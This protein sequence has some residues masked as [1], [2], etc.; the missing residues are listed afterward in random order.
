M[1]LSCVG[2]DP[3]ATLHLEAASSC[4]LW[5]A[6]SKRVGSRAPNSPNAV[7]TAS[8]NRS[9]DASSFEAPNDAA[10]RSSADATSAT[11][12]GTST[13][14]SSCI[15]FVR[16]SCLE[17]SVVESASAAAT[18]TAGA[19]ASSNG[20]SRINSLRS[21]LCSVST[22]SIVSGNVGMVQIALSRASLRSTSNLRSKSRARRHRARGTPFFDE[23]AAATTIAAKCALKA[24]SGS[25][26]ANLSRASTA[27]AAKVSASAPDAVSSRAAPSIPRTF[28]ACVAASVGVNNSAHDAKALKRAARSVLSAFSQGTP[29]L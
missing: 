23:G 3:T 25:N 7:A 28:G 26:D 22:P 17:E 19:S 14:S 1:S 15:I 18:R 4:V 10:A 29:A 27:T 6:T 21:G 13:S 16:S 9:D 5:R 24:S 20:A 2:E 11:S 12:G 8:R